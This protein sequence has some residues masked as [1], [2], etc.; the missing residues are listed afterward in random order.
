M[1]IN[2]FG[3]DIV[4]MMLFFS[5]VLITIVSLLIVMIIP[6]I[7]TFKQ[8]W[9]V[10]AYGFTISIITYMIAILFQFPGFGGR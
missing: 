4:A 6:P 1:I 2:D 10:F 9:Q 5:W 8:N 3:M 7:L